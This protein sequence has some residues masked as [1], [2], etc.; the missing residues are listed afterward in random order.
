MMQI[1]MNMGGAFLSFYHLA[2]DVHTIHIWQEFDM[3]QLLIWQEMGNDG[4]YG[5]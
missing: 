5:R 1:V 2:G 3:V 4:K